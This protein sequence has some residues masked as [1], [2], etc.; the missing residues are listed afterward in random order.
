MGKRG[1]IKGDMLR[2]LIFLVYLNDKY[3]L[4]KRIRISKLKS[5]IGYST[6][7]VY[8][9]LDESE[10]FIRKGDEI[11]P[12]KEGEEYVKKK[13]LPYYKPL[14][15]ISYYIIFFGILLLVHWFLR[16]HYNI[17]IVFDWPVALSFIIVGLVIRFAL[18]PL[19]YYILKATKKI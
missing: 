2:D 15:I 8:N 19:V 13:L 18:L 10:Y 14:N 3:G 7:G 17:I 16:T 9:A 1:L 4:G 6:G 12:S 5:L 11:R